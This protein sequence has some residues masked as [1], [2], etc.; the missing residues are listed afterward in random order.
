MTLRD[1]LARM[2]DGRLK[3]TCAGVDVTRQEVMLLEREIAHL[4]TALKRAK[5]R[6]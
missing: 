3:L 2:Q 5:S 6:P 4:E 1:L